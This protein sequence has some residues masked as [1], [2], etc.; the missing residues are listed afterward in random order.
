VVN[1]HDAIGGDESEVVLC[2]ADGRDERLPRQD[3]Q[4]TAARIVAAA[5]QLRT[6]R[7]AS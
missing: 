1:L 5:V 6:G 4:L 3:K 7:R 2:F